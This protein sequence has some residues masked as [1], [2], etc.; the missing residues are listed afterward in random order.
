MDQEERQLSQ[1]SLFS[2]F[3]QELAIMVVFV[4]PSRQT[5]RMTDEIMQV[6]AY[7]TADCS[8]PLAFPTHPACCTVYIM[9]I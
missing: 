2:P 3:G 8:V 5:G 1:T 9:I 7:S 4:S 6:P